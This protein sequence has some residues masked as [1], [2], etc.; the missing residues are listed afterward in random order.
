M[1]RIIMA[2][3]LT[4]T[5]TSHAAD[6]TQSRNLVSFSASA[7]EDVASDLLIVRLFV[8]HDARE[9]AKAADLVNKTMAA[10]LATAK[11]TKG[12]KAQTQDYRSDPI[13]DEQQKISAWRVHQG[14][15]L[16]SADHD[17]LTAL[18]GT[19][20]ATLAIESVGYGVS[21]SLRET[22]EERLTADAIKRF[23]ARAQQVAASFGRKSYSVV[24]VNLDQRGNMPPPMPYAGRAMAMKADVASPA[25]EAGTQSIEVAVNG[26]IELAP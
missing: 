11:Q 26:T 3:L 13:Y 17:A 12:V 7:K 8:E 15:R 18:L 2:L 20:Q 1:N 16:E 4:F 14:L 6:N 22:V 10:A 19:L 25:I 21:D 5:A 24:N 9:Q 23:S